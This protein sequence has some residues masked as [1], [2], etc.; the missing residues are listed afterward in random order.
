[1]TQ[2]RLTSHDDGRTID[3]RVGDMVI[4]ELPENP[5]TGFRWNEAANPGGIAELHVSAYDSSQDQTLP[6]PSGV[7]M[8]SSGIRHLDRSGYLLE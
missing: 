6:D 5:T 2:I 7:L 3:T 1:M 8:G 4:I